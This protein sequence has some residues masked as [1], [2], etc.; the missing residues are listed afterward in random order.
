MV[1]CGGCCRWDRCAAAFGAG[2]ER[3]ES[4]R[5][6]G[7]IQQV[8]FDRQSEFQFFKMNEAG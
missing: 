1:L 4:I 8:K 2:V 7:F 5:V 6:K 3:A